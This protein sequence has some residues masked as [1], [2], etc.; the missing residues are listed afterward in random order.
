MTD[1]E[2]KRLGN[3]LALLS[4][5]DNGIDGGLYDLVPL[6]DGTFRLEGESGDGA[7]GEPVVFETDG[8]GKVQRLKLGETYT[9]PHEGAW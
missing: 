7:V 1:A 5:Q 4:P 6:G 3:R 9:Y 8:A 2:V